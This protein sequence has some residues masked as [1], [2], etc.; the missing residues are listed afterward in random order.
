[1][2][3]VDMR[4]NL[5]YLPFPRLDRNPLIFIHGF[6]HPFSKSFLNGLGSLSNAPIGVKILIKKCNRY[7]KCLAI[8]S[9]Q[10]LRSKQRS[11]YL[12]TQL[13]RYCLHS[14]QIW[15]S[16]RHKTDILQYRH[17]SRRILLFE[18]LESF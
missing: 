8:T 1:M 4:L 18:N 13:H 5:I 3:I 7:N 6:L 2:S 9:L 11:I 16:P 15:S 12:H 17:D 10:N 14:I